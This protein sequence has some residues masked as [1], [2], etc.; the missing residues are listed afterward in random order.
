MIYLERNDQREKCRNDEKKGHHEFEWKIV[1]RRPVSCCCR[2][3]QMIPSPSSWWWNVLLEQL[4]HGFAVHPPTWRGQRVL[5]A[6]SAPPGG[7]AVSGL[8]L[9]NF[10]PNK[11]TYGWKHSANGLFLFTNQP[12]VNTNSHQST[13]SIHSCEINIFF[14]PLIAKVTRLFLLFCFF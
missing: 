12:E 8:Q 7:A 3:K 2:S 5:D 6:A 9:Q 14:S 10:L 11:E 1:H 4:H 13:I